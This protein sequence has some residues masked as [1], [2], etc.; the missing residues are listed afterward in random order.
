M[1]RILWGV[2]GLFFTQCVGPYTTQSPTVRLPAAYSG[3][4]ESDSLSRGMYP[5][6]EYFADPYLVRLIDSALAHNQELQVLSAEMD[7]ARAEVKARSGEYLPFVSPG[8][9]T[10]LDKVGEY[11]RF[12]AVERSLEVSPGH[13]FPEPFSTYEGGLYAS[14]EI[15]IWKRLR[16]ARRAAFLRYMASAE[17]R[18]FAITRL[19]AEV[20]EAYYELLAIENLLRVLD[21]YI[22][23]QSNAL[24]LVR[25]ARQAG[26]ATQLAVNR[27]EARLL[28][29]QNRRYALLQRRTEVENRLHFLL[30]RMPTQL[31]LYADT[32]LTMQVDTLPMVGLPAALLYNRPD[33]R[34]AE[35]ELQAA[36]IDMQVARA[37]FY[38]SLTLRGSLGMQSFSL[39]SLLGPEA[40]LYSLG[41]D[42]LAPLINRNAL[43][44]AYQSATARQQQALRRYEQTLIQAYTDVLNE[45]A[46]LRNA[47]R[48]FQIKSEEVR[49]LNESVPIATNLYRAAEADYLEVLLTQ[50]EALDARMELIEIKQELLR[51]RIGLYRALGGG[52]R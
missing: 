41:G 3:V 50:V 34:Q 10:D 45:L 48:S 21:E 35:L 43:K 28:H 44:A 8:I 5:W 20:A 47:A 51:A 49:L 12:G 11:T 15:D 38:P 13:R 33:I 27:F 52:W 39:A 37:A 30:G 36:R 6:R 22:Q 29:T 32:F 4:A 25:V 2:V 23:I 9:R 18:R 7:I 16:N 40:L 24:T 42:V 1:K 19:V 46:R 31:T 14:W 17:A 26:K